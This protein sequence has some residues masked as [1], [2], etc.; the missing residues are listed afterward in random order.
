MSKLKSAG[1]AR[2]TTPLANQRAHYHRIRHT[3]RR[4]LP[5][6]L[7]DVQISRQDAVTRVVALARQ[8]QTDQPELH[9]L[10][11]LFQLDAEELAEA[12]LA[13]ETLQAVRRSTCFL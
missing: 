12:G 3:N 7:P 5:Y 13:Y 2:R 8:Q 9:L 11:S 6:S 4:Q 10:I 1:S